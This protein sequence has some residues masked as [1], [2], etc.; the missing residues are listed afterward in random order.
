MFCLLSDPAQP[1]RVVRSRR[2]Q[3]H[4][5][6]RAVLFHS[7]GQCVSGA[8]VFGNSMDSR[9]AFVFFPAGVSLSNNRLGTLCPPQSRVLWMQTV[10]MFIGRSKLT[11]LN[12]TTIASLF[13]TVHAA[14]SF[15][16]P[17][18][19]RWTILNH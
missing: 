18:R 12:L 5:L 17:G 11:V 7:E 15:S 14:S 9:W 19:S 1:L 16:L 4:S 2:K 13:T 10:L 8:R 6:R 3:L